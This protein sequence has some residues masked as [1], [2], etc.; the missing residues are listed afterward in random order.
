MFG[1]YEILAIYNDRTNIIPFDSSFLSLI[2]FHFD[3]ISFDASF[4]ADD[5]FAVGLFH[6]KIL[7]EYTICCDIMII[8][9]IRGNDHINR[10]NQPH[11]NL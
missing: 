8:V 9:L 7:S 2:D 5:Y 6:D 11:Y 3:D 4:S 1:G 10:M